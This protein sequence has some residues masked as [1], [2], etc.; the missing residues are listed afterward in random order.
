M[1]LAYRDFTFGLPGATI[2]VRLRF[3]SFTTK[4]VAGYSQVD[5][6][7]FHHEKCVSGR[8]ALS[9][10]LSPPLAARSVFEAEKVI[11]H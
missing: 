5:S 11:T 1:K 10:L 8:S 3:A 7:S 2:S 6:N 4:K 9:L